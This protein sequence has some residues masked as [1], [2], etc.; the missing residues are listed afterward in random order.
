MPFRPCPRRQIE[1]YTDAVGYAPGDQVCFHCS[2]HPA[3]KGETSKFKI[4]V[5]RDGLEPTLA[6]EQSGLEV[7][8]IP[9]PPNA[10]AA[11]C[12]WP[13]IFTWTVPADLPSAFYIVYAEL[14]DADQISVVREESAGQPGAG[15]PGEHCLCVRANEPAADVVFVLATNTWCSYNY[16][17]GCFSFCEIVICRACPDRPFPLPENGR[18][19]ALTAQVVQTTIAVELLTS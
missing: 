3:I 17:G 19:I 18:C 1:L 13:V 16:W 8:H 15:G 6:F 7:V 12:G 5:Y 4:S 9:T 11:G 10:F 14:T 2:G